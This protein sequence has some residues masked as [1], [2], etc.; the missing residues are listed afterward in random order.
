MEQPQGASILNRTSGTQAIH[1][2]IRVLR[3]IAR[4]RDGGVGLAALCQ[5]TGLIK[6]TV[7]RLTTAL[8]SEGL[9]EQDA[10]TRRYFLGPECHALGLIASD[11]FGLHKIA[12]KP[13]ARLAQETGDAAFFSI[14]QDIYS[15]CLLREEGG[16]PL[17]SRVLLAG[18][19]HPLGVGGGSQAMLAALDDSEIAYCLE[20][21]M[22]DIARLYPSYTPAVL[23]ELIQRGRAKGYSVNRGLVLAGSWGIG[24]A[25]RSADGQVVG[26]LSIATVESRMNPERESQ[27]YKLL[28]KEADGLEKYIRMHGLSHTPAP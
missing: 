27:L 7:H 8:I 12:A 13:V 9:A 3:C 4:S 22:A 24:V 11:R 21:N 10:K 28:R 5:Q 14:R 2:A 1:R 25:V 18:D 20:Q 6:S 19:R 16:Y 26:A 15:L 23:A 17:K